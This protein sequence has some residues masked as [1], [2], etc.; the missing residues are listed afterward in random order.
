[1]FKEG[2]EEIKMQA[3]KKK[4][5]S[6]RGASITFALLIF[7]VCAVV[8]SV[9]LAAGTAASGR[10]AELAEYEQRYHAVNSAAELLSKE[11]CSGKT[12]VKCQKT[13]TTTI[14]Q[15]FDSD[16]QFISETRKD[17]EAVETYQ[18]PDIS[19]VPDK[20]PTEQLLKTL[21]KKVIGA[22]RSNAAI[23]NGLPTN[24]TP[25]TYTI[26]SNGDRSHLKVEATATMSIIQAD[27]QYIGELDLLIKNSTESE[28]PT[29]SVLMVFKTD[30]I[31]LKSFPLSTETTL[32]SQVEDASGRTDTL[33]E[34]QAELKNQIIRWNLLG[35]TVGG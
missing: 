23:W 22:D 12:I 1:M 20:A 17:D 16:Y 10:L 30:P 34:T 19:T 6:Q 21:A 29:Y 8:G 18:E 13:T 2:Q 3:I 24:L 25:V 31:S 9:V 28:K 4:L 14:V 5:R 33:K 32:I 11:I 26:T 15:T 7:L 27:E 35:M